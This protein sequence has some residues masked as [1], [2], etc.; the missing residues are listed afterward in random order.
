MAIYYYIKHHFLQTAPRHFNALQPT[1][2]DSVAYFML[3]KTV[4]LHIFQTLSKI[5]GRQKLKVDSSNIRWSYNL[6]TI[7]LMMSYVHSCSDIS[8]ESNVLQGHC[9]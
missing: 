9:D 4:M 8:L 5:Q 3:M 6:A 2:R 1:Q 7:L